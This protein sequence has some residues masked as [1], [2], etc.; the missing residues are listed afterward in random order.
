VK[1]TVREPRRAI[2]KGQSRETGNTGYTKRNKE[3]KQQQQ[4]HNMC[5]TPKLISFPFSFTSIFFLTNIQYLFTCLKIKLPCSIISPYSHMLCNTESGFA[6][7][8]VVLFI[9]GDNSR[10]RISMA[11]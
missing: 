6:Q 5:R 11:K 2:K 4:Q 9:G 7:L 1:I 8:I 10:K 3:K